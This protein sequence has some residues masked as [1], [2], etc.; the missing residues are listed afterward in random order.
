MNLGVPIVLA[1]WVRSMCQKSKHVLAIFT[2]QHR[3][4]TCILRPLLC[5]NSF[6]GMQTTARR[7]TQSPKTMQNPSWV[8]SASWLIQYRSYVEIL[9]VLINI[10]KPSHEWSQGWPVAV[11]WSA[12]GCSRPAQTPH[13]RQDGYGTSLVRLCKTSIIEH[14]KCSMGPIGYC[15]SFFYLNDRSIDRL[16]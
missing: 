6:L 1:K 9:T 15:S 12:H 4:Q 14:P 16:Y 3:T 2:Q 5:F 7:S 8:G 13:G 11:A 10:D